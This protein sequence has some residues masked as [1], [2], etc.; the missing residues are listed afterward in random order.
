[1]WLQ[2]AP[3]GAL[4]TGTHPAWSSIL[5]APGLLKGIDIYAGCSRYWQ[6]LLS[7]QL[8]RFVLAVSFLVRPG[9]QGHRPQEGQLQA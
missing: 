9:L 6:H 1:M 2:G 5:T 3:G 8:H 4:S 7:Q